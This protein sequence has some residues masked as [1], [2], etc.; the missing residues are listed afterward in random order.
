M[1][2]VNVSAFLELLEWARTHL[3]GRFV[4]LSTGSVY[5]PDPSPRSEDD[6][7]EPASFYAATKLAAEF[8]LR[9]YR[10]FFRSITLRVFT[11][12]GPGQEGKLV[13]N[14]IRS[15]RTGTPIEIRSAPP[16]LLAPIFVDDCLGIVRE[17]LRSDRFDQAVYNVGAPEPC[18]IEHLIRTI[19]A[20][21]GMTADV[22]RA[23][24]GGALS[25][26]PSVSRLLQTLPD[27]RWTPLSDG[28]R[29]M[30]Q[31]PGLEE[32]ANTAD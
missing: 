1:C 23:G 17:A 2:A 5:R 15:I 14:L 29:R 19:E 32:P 4:Y 13:S 10:L 30:V 26:V 8:M 27:L 28:I 6:P 25:V 12:Y 31:P 11:P 7:C 16:T 20:E 18:T 3:Q 24:S 21:L 9:E 22:V